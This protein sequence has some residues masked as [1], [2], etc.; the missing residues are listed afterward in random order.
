MSTDA[1]RWQRVALVLG[2]AVVAL[3]GALSWRI[4][5]APQAVEKGAPWAEVWEDVAPG[6]LLVELASPE[7]RVGAAFA[8]SS[9]EAV[10]ARHLVL[11]APEVTLRD[12]NGGV[13]P[14]RV[15]GTDA[16]ADLAL[17]EVDAR[18]VP[19]RL[20]SSEGLR[21]G[22]PV[23][24]IGNPFGLGHSLSTGVVSHRG[25]RLAT[26]SDGPRVGFLQLSIP[27][28]PGNSGGPVFDQSGQV[29]G[30]LAGTH[31]QGQAIAF[32]VPV[33]AVVDG[34]EALRGGRHISRAFLG[35]RAE[36]EGDALIV[37]SVVASGPADRA[38]IRPGDTLTAIDGHA[39]ASPDELASLLDELPGGEPIS[40]RLRRDGQ[41]VLAD[42]VLGDWA[43]Q[44]IVVAGLTLRA[45]PG[46]GGQVVAVRPGSRAE[47]AGLQVGDVVRRI[48]GLPVQAPVD[49][50]GALQGA[51]P[52]TVEIERDGTAMLAN[53][54]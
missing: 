6:V 7:P 48:D 31:T 27:L 33:E 16:R 35:L 29:V 51:R 39:V 3:T 40:M 53:L 13:W 8:V 21:V 30:V 49:V 15:V 37:A 45:E 36:L 23:M 28:N 12:V 46:S 1:Q 26:S 54:E 11:G 42:V 41:L 18:L 43:E 4:A 34:L 50:K 47:R 2:L 25:L 22:D 17:L 14:A 20:G 38:G 9:T 10:T 24:A 52:A 44:P 5:R 32:A 19:A